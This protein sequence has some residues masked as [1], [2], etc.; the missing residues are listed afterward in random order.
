MRKKQKEARTNKTKKGT[1]H[2]AFVAKRSSARVLKI[3]IIIDEKWEFNAA[4]YARWIFILQVRQVSGGRREDACG[5]GLTRRP[6][7]SITTVL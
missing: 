3:S 4:R 1:M 2:D 6:L 7:R 5:H